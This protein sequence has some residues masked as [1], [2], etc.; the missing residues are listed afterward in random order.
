MAFKQTKYHKWKICNRKI[1]YEIKRVYYYGKNTSG[2]H[3]IFCCSTL[4]GHWDKSPYCHTGIQFW[5]YCTSMDSCASVTCG[6]TSSHCGIVRLHAGM[7]DL[8]HSQTLTSGQVSVLRLSSLS[9]QDHNKKI[10]CI[11]EN[12]VGEKESSLVLNILCGFGFVTYC[13]CYRLYY[14]TNW[15][16]NCLVLF[17]H[18]FNAQFR[19]KSRNWMTQSRT[20]TGVS[21]L[22]WLVRD[23]HT[24]CETSVLIHKTNRCDRSQFLSFM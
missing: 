9:S 12:I 23:T 5:W 13:T 10:S 19:Q 11:A 4:V 16:F 1:L 6:R 3:E 15:S 2:P 14:L 20:T 24:R 8:S 21:H 7:F 22:V 17:Y 18:L